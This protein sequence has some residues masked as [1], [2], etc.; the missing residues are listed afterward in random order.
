[1]EIALGPVGSVFL[2]GLVIAGFVAGIWLV[3]H[4]ERH[5]KQL[6]SDGLD[7]KG[8]VVR[9][10][11]G[12]HANPYYIRY[13]YRDGR[14]QERE[15]KVQVIQDFWVNHPEGSPIA[16]VYSKSR[17]SISGVKYQ[18]EEKRKALAKRVE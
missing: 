16:V 6:V 4:R 3:V 2:I 10:S 5:L 12:G 17:P 15:H 14:G 11:G 9:Q 1:M 7:V 8:I 18:V 13:R